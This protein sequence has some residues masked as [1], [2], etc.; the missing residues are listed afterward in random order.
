[1]DRKTKKEAC[2]VDVHLKNALRA[3]SCD[4]ST[5]RFSFVK[6]RKCAKTLQT[7]FF[8]KPHKLCPGIPAHFKMKCFDGSDG[9]YPLTLLAL[10]RHCDQLKIKFVSNSLRNYLPD[11]NAAVKNL[12][13]CDALL[14]FVKEV[15]KIFLKILHTCSKL[16]RNTRNFWLLLHI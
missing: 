12:L 2:P 8:P 1:M 5:S 15:K 10:K 14:S 6:D 7:N 13:H 16:K 3:A 9:L 4:E 11:S